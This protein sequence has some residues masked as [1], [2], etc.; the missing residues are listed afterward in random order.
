[1]SDK[2]NP[3]KDFLDEYV[4]SKNVLFYVRNLKFVNTKIETDTDNAFYN[5]TGEY[6][7][8]LIETLKEF[9]RIIQEENKKRS[10]STFLKE[11]DFW[12][13]LVEMTSNDD[14]V[15]II[16]YPSFGDTDDKN[17]KNDKNVCFDN[18]NES[19]IKVLQN[20]SNNYVEEDVTL[21]R[22]FIN[23]YRITQ[24]KYQD[25]GTSLPL[26]LYT[27][28]PCFYIGK[29]FEGTIAMASRKK[30]T[31]EELKVISSLFLS[32]LA[33]NFAENAAAAAAAAAIRKQATRTA[34]AA[35]MSR[36]MSHNLGSHFI[37]NTKNYFGN[38]VD[39]TNDDQLKKDYRGIKHTLQYIQ[40]RMDF[41]ATIVSSDHFP[42]GAVNIKSQILDELT[43]DEFGKRHEKPTTNF[44]L[45]FLVFSEDVSKQSN[46]GIHTKSKLSIELIS[47]NGKRFENKEDNENQEAKNEIAQLSF[48]VPGGILG[49]H[50]IFTII[51][52]I[53][54]NSAK[55]DK[56]SVVYQIVCFRKYNI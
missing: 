55:H 44:L 6:K 34:I 4:K 8:I 10:M 14:K 36:N 40:E 53:I 12:A 25:K 39:L 50:A 27:F 22:N 15:R 23:N 30:L 13:V 47:P 16:P 42:Y 9:D 35:I 52:N 19:I 17:D 54:R 46:R 32:T 43:P 49:R 26:F 18:N 3:I 7:N 31:V 2:P 33:D 45:D 20:V 29:Y 5:E 1:M 11:Q 48:A 56:D 51:E 21:F 38:Q 24:K 37:T 41:I 28:N